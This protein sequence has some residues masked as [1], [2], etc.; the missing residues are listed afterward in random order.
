MIQCLHNFALS[1]YGGR[2]P[3]RVSF[4]FFSFVL[5]YFFFQFCGGN[6]PAGNRMFVHSLIRRR[7]KKPSCF[8]PAF[9]IPIACNAAKSKLR[10]SREETNLL[11]KKPPCSIGGSKHIHARK[12]R[13]R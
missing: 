2:K 11:T 9:A 10:I 4:F 3:P 8:F 1:F 12:R 5:E 13:I 7:L 6:L